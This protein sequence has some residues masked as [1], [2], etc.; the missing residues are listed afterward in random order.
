MKTLTQKNKWLLAVIGLIPLT[1]VLNTFESAL[2][3]GI[4]LA[5][6]VLI[7]NLILYWLYKVVDEK[8]HIV[9]LV[10]VTTLVT[11][12]LVRVF[13]LFFYEFYVNVGIYFVGLI[14]NSVLLLTL[15]KKE[16]PLEIQIFDNL[17]MISKIFALGLIF[18]LIRELLGTGTISLGLLFG[19]NISLGSALSGYAMT[20]FN[21]PAGGLIILSIIAIVV[22]LIVDKESEEN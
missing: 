19:D 11:A 7:T 14:I 15:S 17:K 10:V 21:E 12:L 16:E 20:L 2:G 22:N 3:I 8:L 4:M 5:L 1:A 9:S 18:G 13:E 6:V